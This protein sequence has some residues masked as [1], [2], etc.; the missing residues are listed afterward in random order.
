MAGGHTEGKLLAID[1]R[2]ITV[3]EKG[4]RQTIERRDVFRVRYAN[5]RRR[6]TL[7]GMAIG[8]AA[9]ALILGAAA[10]SSNPAAAG[11]GAVLGLGAGALTGGVL[12]IGT[13]LYE[14]ETPAQREAAARKP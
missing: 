13:P 5:I 12:P 10:D 9:G 3:Q 4:E 1:D 7:L 14:A 8:A 2:A 11:L 6:N